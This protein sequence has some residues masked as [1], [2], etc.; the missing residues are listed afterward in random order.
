[1]SFIDYLI[2][3]GFESTEQVIEQ[4]GEEILHYFYQRYEEQCEIVGEEPEY[5]D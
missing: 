3:E 1:M 5:N 2:S 4:K